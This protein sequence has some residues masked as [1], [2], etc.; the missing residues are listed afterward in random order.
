VTAL[1]QPL[2]LE[3]AFRLIAELQALVDEQA[4]T[5]KA[6]AKMIKVQAKAIAKLEEKR[7]LAA[8]VREG[9]R[10]ARHDPAQEDPCAAKSESHWQTF[11]RS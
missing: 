1:A 8:R 10:L 3:T 5:I 11:G 6:Q 4:K 2:T 9:L 7:V